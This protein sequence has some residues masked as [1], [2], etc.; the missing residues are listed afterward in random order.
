MRFA[1]AS[2]KGGTGKTTVAVA[3][4][5]YLAGQAP[6]AVALLDLD[7][8]EPNAALF[9]GVPNN[10][11]GSD[12]AHGSSGCGGSD[13][14][15][16]ALYAPETAAVTVPKP[17]LDESRCDRCGA[18][19]AACR[20]NAIA[21]LPTGPMLFPELCHACGACVHAC[22]ARALHEEPC[23]IGRVRVGACGGLR[24]GDGLLSIGQSQAPPVIEAV[25]EHATQD[26]FAVPREGVGPG[27]PWVVMDCPP[28]T[29][30][31]MVSAVRSAD[32]VALVTEPTPFGLHDLTLAVEAV[33]ALGQ[34]FGVVVNRADPTDTRVQRYCAVE[35]IPILAVI[36]DDR[37][38]AE[39]YARGVPL[40]TAAPSQ[41]PVFAALH[42]GL[43]ELARGTGRVIDNRSATG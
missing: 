25:M 26:P 12:G 31:A 34:A 20:F 43:T 8:E 2:G 33:R 1:I 23:V 9:L 10:S 11:D 7:V 30:C 40:L 5:Q 19:A 21:A 29:S 3:L 39:A 35:G 22:S 32:A 14:S 16:E 27:A 6:G 36:P 28:G 15:F 41:E 38:I 18:C 37:R 24:V 4:A 42:E 13:G 17:V